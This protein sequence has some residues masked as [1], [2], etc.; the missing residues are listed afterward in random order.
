[1]ICV[2]EERPIG[3]HAGRDLE[4]L[5]LGDI[6]RDRIGEAKG[7][8]LIKHHEGDTGDRLRHR[9]DAKDRVLGHRRTRSDVLVAERFEVGDLAVARDHRRDAG[10]LTVVDELLH[11]GVEPFEALARHA[12]RFRRDDRQVSRTL[13]C[14]VGND[15]SIAGSRSQADEEH[16]DEW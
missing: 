5:E 7:P 11:A 3:A 4:V 13:R 14:D 10:E 9:V 8:L 16:G 15:G 1:M 2:L 12:D 6:L